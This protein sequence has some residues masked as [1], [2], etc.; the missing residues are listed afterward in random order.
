MISTILASLGCGQAVGIKTLE[1]S[2]F[3]T[4]DLVHDASKAEESASPGQ[5]ADIVDRIR[6]GRLW[7]HG[8]RLSTVCKGS[9]Q[10]TGQ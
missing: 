8:C 1:M 6:A 10:A 3:A 4:P 5:I 9:H 7:L 2:L